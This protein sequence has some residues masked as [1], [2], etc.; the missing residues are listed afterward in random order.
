[1]S[2]D[3]YDSDVEPPEDVNPPFDMMLHHLQQQVTPTA[4]DMRNALRFMSIC[5]LLTKTPQWFPVILRELI[6][7]R[8]Q[9]LQEPNLILG[10]A[11]YYNL[12]HP[13]MDDYGDLH[14]SSVGQQI[15]IYLSDGIGLYT[16]NPK[17]Y[18]DGIL[19]VLAHASLKRRLGRP[20]YAWTRKFVDGSWGAT[21]SLYY[22][23]PFQQ[24]IDNG[25]VTGLEIVHSLEAMRKRFEIPE[26]RAFLHNTAA[27]V[28]DQVLFAYAFA[29]IGWQRMRVVQHLPFLAMALRHNE[30]LHD[31]TYVF[32]NDHNITLLQRGLPIIM[33]R[34][35]HA[36]ILRSNSLALTGFH[37]LDSELQR[38]LV[39]RCHG[40]T[41]NTSY[42]PTA[43]ILLW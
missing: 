24:M 35:L 6:R 28:S 42:F 26:F 8:E 14:I 25:A 1:M 2:S 20:S 3:A 29:A 37:S 23:E 5:S 39:G 7:C 19:W 36:G 12:F 9:N 33:S 13:Q 30:R 43:A 16:T 34:L 15:T 4:T 38:A 18:S 22:G 21:T 11:E 10:L 17:Y 32:F 40:K 31:E 41:V 27:V